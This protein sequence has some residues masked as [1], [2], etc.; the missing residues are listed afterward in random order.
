MFQHFNDVIL[1]KA[2]KRVC[3]SEIE[4]HLL[5]FW[6]FSSSQAPSY[7]FYL[8]VRFLLQFVDLSD[9][10][11]ATQ[12]VVAYSECSYQAGFETI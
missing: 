7:I 10:P 6:E 2:V 11:F 1:T 12:C 3:T 5:P 4:K 8:L 9:V